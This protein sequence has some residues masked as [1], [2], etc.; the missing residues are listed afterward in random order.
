MKTHTAKTLPATTT[1]PA[2]FY[3]RNCWGWTIRYEVISENQVK[4]VRTYR[5]MEIG[6]ITTSR[7]EARKHYKSL[8]NG[9]FDT[10]AGN[11]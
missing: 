1:K 5:G 4:I 6:E 10:F 9:G 8:L 3:L 7:E 11:L 2:R